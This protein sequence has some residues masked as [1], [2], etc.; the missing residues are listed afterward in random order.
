MVPEECAVAGVMNHCFP[1]KSSGEVRVA[2]DGTLINAWTQ[3]VAMSELST[4]ASQM[5]ISKGEA[6]FKSKFDIRWAFNLVEVHP[7]TRK[8]LSFIWRGIRYWYLRMPFGVKNATAIFFQWIA[9]VIGKLPRLLYFVDDLL[10]YAPRVNQHLQDLLHLAS[11]LM[12]HGIPQRAVKISLL[13]LVVTFVGR[14]ITEIGIRPTE[15]FIDAILGVTVPMVNCKAVQRFLGQVK[16]IHS[17]VK[18]A[19]VL[20]KPLNSLTG[21]HFQWT[22]VHTEAVEKLKHA[23]KKSYVIEFVD[24]TNGS[25]LVLQTDASDF[26]MGAALK[27]DGR[28]LRVYSYAFDKTQQRWSTVD[29]E[30]FAVVKAVCVFRAFLFGR[31]FVIEVDQKSLIWLFKAVQ[32]DTGSAKNF[33]WCVALQGFDFVIRHIAGTK[34]DTADA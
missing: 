8:Y 28:L 30:A 11:V 12:E 32:D 22:K 1:R 23:V 24:W 5:V 29:Q 34:N 3:P 7:D 25:P 20:A 18:D 10:Q 13:K 27:Q 9:A 4:D 21:S 14:E 26:G 17:H 15:T 19:S 16:W 2:Y 6:T 33:R 31:P